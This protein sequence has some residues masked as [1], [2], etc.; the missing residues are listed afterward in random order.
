MANWRIL[1]AALHRYLGIGLCLLF[2]MWF[3]SG[4]V[5]L[6]HPFPAL[7]EAQRFACLEPIDLGTTAIHASLFERA[8]TDDTEAFRLTSVAGRAVVHQH[9]AESIDS[10]WADT[11]E[12][13]IRVST[14]QARTVAERC[15]HGPASSV[16]TIGDDQW[17]VH[18]G[19]A[20]HRP[21]YRVRLDDPSATVLY[22]SSRTGEVV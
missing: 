2:A 4:I 16:E 8:S 10:Y 19:F 12:G 5:M 9:G 7:T 22:V 13:P 18:E 17:T 14:A 6:F 21:L 20:G 3:A 15:G 1:L 11:G